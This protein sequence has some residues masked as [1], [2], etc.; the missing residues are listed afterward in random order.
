MTD[1]GMTNNYPGVFAAIIEASDAA[2]V[3]R[4]PVNP[5]QYELQAGVFILP[6]SQLREMLTRIDDPCFLAAVVRSA[7]RGVFPVEYLY[8]G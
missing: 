4:R 2:C 1:A 3:Q 5:D 7:S 8:G 6:I